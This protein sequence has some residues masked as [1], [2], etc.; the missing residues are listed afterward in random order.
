[1]FF[2]RPSVNETHKSLNDSA[3]KEIA[4]YQRQSK[5]KLQQDENQ[6]LRY[7]KDLGDYYNLTENQVI[8]LKLLFYRVLRSQIVNGV[9]PVDTGSPLDITKLIEGCEKNKLN[10]KK[11]QKFTGLKVRFDEP[12]VNFTALFFKSGKINCVGL[13]NDTEE[14]VNQILNTFKKYQMDLFDVQTFTNSIKKIANRVLSIKI[15]SLIPLNKLI[16]FNELSNW[17]DIKYNSQ[18]F[19]GVIFRN[20]N[21]KSKVIFFRTGS[22][23]FT[24]ITSKVKKLLVLKSFLETLSAY[25]E[26][27]NRNQSK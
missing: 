10:Y 8:G 21:F 3:K 1:M 22:S 17:R 16:Y 18:S 26:Y 20:E 19:P 12:N 24:G 13:K 7:I 15:P 6:V 14:Y 23:I 27:Y 5:K 25:L 2:E 9:C 11:Y 4:Q